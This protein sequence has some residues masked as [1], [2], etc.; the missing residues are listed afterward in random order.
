MLKPLRTE[1]RRTLLRGSS[2]ALTG[3]L[4]LTPLALPPAEPARAAAQTPAM[5]S[6]PEPG[7]RRNRNLRSRAT[8]PVQLDAAAQSAEA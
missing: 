1:R 6:A 2:F 4:L 3:A 7:N 5:P 8:Q